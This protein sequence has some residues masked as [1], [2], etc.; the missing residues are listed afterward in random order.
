VNIVDRLLPRRLHE[1]GHEFSSWW[2]PQTLAGYELE[3]FRQ[4][5]SKALAAVKAVSVEMRPGWT[6]KQ[7]A[8]LVDTHLRDSGVAEFFHYSFAWFGERTRFDGIR[9]Y[10][11][12]A[13]SNRV[14]R[15][16]EVYI[17]DTAP[18][19]DGYICDI[20]FTT[21]AGTNPAYETV[22]KYLWHLRENLPRWALEAPTGGE[23]WK[24]VAES[25]QEQGL[26][27]IHK[28]Y[29]F[30][31]LGHRVHRVSRAWGRSRVLNFGLAS[32]MELSSR[33]LW[34]QLLTAKHDR[35]LR[36]AWAIEPHLGT[37]TFGAKFEEI[38]YV[39]DQSA[40]WIHPESLACLPQKP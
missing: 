19:V 26:D 5:Q 29:P 34:D 36:G 16:N 10:A 38:L 33:L 32:Y 11:E 39:T 8:A 28:R 14:L 22:L 1:W 40:E 20:G 13:P 6:E 27:C 31:V 7:A 23:L 21:C 24:R 4:A 3:G 37:L 9:T 25:F 2:R 17:L 35:P 15:E 18:I 30:E 12:F